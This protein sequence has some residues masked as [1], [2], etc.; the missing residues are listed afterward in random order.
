MLT[1]IF[2]HSETYIVVAIQWISRQNYD[3]CVLS[4]KEFKIM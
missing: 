1:I 3:F 2:L 4:S